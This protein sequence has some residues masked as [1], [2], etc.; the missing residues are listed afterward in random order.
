[1]KSILWRG[2]AAAGARPAIGQAW[3]IGV[4]TST[5]PGAFEA[6]DMNP[7]VVGQRLPHFSQ[8]PRIS[9]DMTLHPSR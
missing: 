6:A 1:M 8:A 2:A 5:A 3:L 4:S 9:S 7:A